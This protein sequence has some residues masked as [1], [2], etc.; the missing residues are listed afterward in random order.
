[1]NFI[2]LT[3]NHCNIKRCEKEK[4]IIIFHINFQFLFQIHGYV[5]TMGHLLEIAW[6]RLETVGHPFTEYVPGMV[7]LITVRRL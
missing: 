3:S 4:K 6:K 7:I 2:P 5:E 1:M